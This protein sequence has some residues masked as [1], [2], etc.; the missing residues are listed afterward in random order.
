MSKT[1]QIPPFFKITV[2]HLKPLSVWCVV[3]VVSNSQVPVTQAIN[4]GIQPLFLP[5]QMGYAGIGVHIFPSLIE[6]AIEG[7]LDSVH[8]HVVPG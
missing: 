2:L 5:W 1:R 8:V 3:V 6:Q 4:L 7:G